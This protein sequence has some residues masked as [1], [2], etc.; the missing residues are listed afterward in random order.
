MA[1]IINNEL[2]VS[3]ESLFPQIDPKAFNPVEKRYLKLL[4]KKEN[5]KISLSKKEEEFLANIS[6]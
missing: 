5:L 1:K 3:F 6:K 4:K 2:E